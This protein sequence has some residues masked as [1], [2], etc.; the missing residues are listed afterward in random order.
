M[1][2]K[3]KLVNSDIFNFTKKTNIFLLTVVL[4]NLFNLS[5]CLYEDQIGKFDW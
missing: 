3:K 4:L 5:E 1:G 2:F